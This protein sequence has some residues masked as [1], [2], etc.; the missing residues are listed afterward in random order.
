MKKISVIINARLQ[1]SRM[2]NKMVRP[3][4]GTDLLEIALEKLDKLDF[5]E[6]R[7]LAV[8]ESE[9]KKKAQKF[10]NIEILERNLEAVSPG[11][12]H[13]MVTFE[14]Y[15]RVPTEYFFVINSCAAFL[16]IET[17]KAAYD[18]F[19]KTNYNSYI[20]VEKT[21]DWTFS[22]D[23]KPL[24]HKNPDTFQNT[25]DGQFF[26]RATHAFYIANKDYF[27]NNDGKL[28]N[29]QKNDPYLIEMPTDEAFDVDTDIEFDISQYLYGLKQK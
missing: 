8:N 29:L 19:Q 26:F 9:L 7:F 11:P 6:H 4:F 17:I 22:D 27:K 13:P 5:F 15:T 28:W 24:T 25:S 23:G 10:S 21:R 20:A 3:F 1:S 14:H 2:Q 18:V 12:H 16:S